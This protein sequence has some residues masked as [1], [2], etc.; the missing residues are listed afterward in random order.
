MKHLKKAA[1]AV[2]AAAIAFSLAACRSAGQAPAP[3]PAAQQ[4]EFDDFLMQDFISTMESEYTAL[5][6]YLQNPAAF[7]VDMSKVR[8]GLG[9]RPDIVSQRQALQA[10][11]EAYGQFLS[12][13]RSKLTPNSRTPMTSMNFRRR[14]PLRWAMKS[15]TTMRSCSRAWAACTISFPPCWP[16]GR[17]AARRM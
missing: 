9:S 8:P 5:H 10:A 11:E 13:D 12:F 16:I 3:S 4:Q 7:G 15:S 2:L 17:C 14:L 1:A 6:V